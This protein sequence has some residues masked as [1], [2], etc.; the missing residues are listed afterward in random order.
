MIENPTVTIG[1][2]YLIVEYDR[3]GNKSFSETVV[4]KI[5]PS[6]EFAI[7]EQVDSAKYWRWMK[8]SEVEIVECLDV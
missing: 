6:K 8:I 4:R 1:S 5:S 3:Y 7:F 2:R